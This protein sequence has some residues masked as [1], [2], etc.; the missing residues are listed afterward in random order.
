MQLIVALEQVRACAC[1]RLWH[2]VHLRLRTTLEEHVHAA[3]RTHHVELLQ[4]RRRRRHR[5]AA[6]NCLALVSRQ[7]LRQAAD[8]RIADEVGGGGAVVAKRGALQ[9]PGEKEDTVN[10]G[11]SWGSGEARPAAASAEGGGEH[12]Q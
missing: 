3:A 9:Q 10:I 1:A 7:A 6:S 11:M 12:G 2:S 8:H 4:R 5:D